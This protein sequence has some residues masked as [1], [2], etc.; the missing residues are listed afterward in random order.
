MNKHY[1]VIVGGGGHAGCEACLASARMGLSTLLVTFNKDSIGYTSCNPS[2]GCVGKGQLVKEIDAMG[3]EMA[4]AADASCI[5][6]RLLNSSK[7]YAARSSR[8][9]IDRKK[10]NEYMRET[11]L[12]QDGLDILEDEVTGIIVKNDI[13]EGVKTAGNGPISGRKVVLTTGTFMNGLIHIGL[14]HH[15]GGRI[16]DPA[17][18]GLSEDL[19]GYGFNVASLKTGTPTRLNGKT[20]DFSVMEKQDG[21]DL[22]IPFSFSNEKISLEQMSCYLTRTN[23]KTHEIIKRGLDRSPLYSGKIKSTGVRYCPS[24]EDKIIRFADRQSHLIF[25]EPEGIDTFRYYPNGISTSLPLDVQEEMIH[26]IKGLEKAEMMVPAY[27]IEYD[28]VD[29]TQMLPTL[30]TKIINGLFLAGQINGTTGYEEAAALGFMAGVNAALQVKKEG[31]L[32]LERSR[33]YIGVLIDDLVTKGTREPYRMFTSRV[34]Y[35][36][37]IREDNADVRLADTGK[38]TGL[39]PEKLR[40]KARLKLAKAEEEEKRLKSVAVFPGGEADVLLK[41]RGQAPLSQK[42]D[43]LYLL[44]RPGISY[45]DVM[46]LDH[47]ENLLDHYEKVQLEVNVK[48]SGY[49]ERELSKIRKFED[50]EKIKIPDDFIYSDISGLSNEIKEKLTE[51]KPRCLG[52]ASRISGVTPAAVTILMVKLKAYH[53]KRDV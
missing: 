17:S 7:G 20:I 48:Y 15:P 8:M 26:S 1:D 38:R 18:K 45:D 50:L 10:Y 46:T 53:E 13:C 28:Y 33:A 36:I 2:I 5:Q 3:G 47:E 43:L 6:Y 35:R 14:Q 30:E 27:G 16:G 22:I 4:K 31:S 42:T 51:V 29:P 34:E 39:S 25:L 21:D 37:V 12:S 41:S 52:Q 11:V 23:R 40:E 49:I 24:I 44:K 19:A 9:Q 32:I